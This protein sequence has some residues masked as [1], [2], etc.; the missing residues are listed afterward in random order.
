MFLGLL[1]EH[2]DGALAYVTQRGERLPAPLL[3]LTPGG[4]TDLVGLGA[5]G[6]QTLTGAF[7][8][9]GAHGV[10]MRLRGIPY[11]VG[12]RP[13]FV[14]QVLCLLPRPL[15]DGLGLLL[16]QGEEPP[17]PFAEALVRLR[18]QCRH[19]LPQTD[20]LGL[21]LP[22]EHGEPGGPF[23]GGVTVPGQGGG[24]RVDL[25]GAVAA[26]PYGHEPLGRHR[27]AAHPGTP[28]RRTTQTDA[29]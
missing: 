7:V 23:P 1:G 11:A 17:G 15:P 2:P 19:D 14:H 27:C 4:D 28:L 10:G 8:R 22:G 20:R 12:V 24:E 21:H 9:L 29:K 26:P 3:H 25:F 16:G 18:G 13:R 5:R 6:E